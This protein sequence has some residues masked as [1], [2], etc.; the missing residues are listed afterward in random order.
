M[1]PANV[2]EDTFPSYGGLCGVMVM[3]SACDSR[4]RGFGFDCWPFRCQIATLGKLFT[5][6][7]LSDTKQYNLVPVT[8]QRCPA[9]GKVTVGLSSH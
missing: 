8:R 4:G 7:C 1:H 3:P 6:M 9:A 5:R 2:L